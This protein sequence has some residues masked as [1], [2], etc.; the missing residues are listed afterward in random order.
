MD[1]GCYSHAV[2][3]REYKHVIA[4]HDG[5]AKR[6]I[7]SS[8]LIFCTSAG[9]NRKKRFFLKI[10]AKTVFDIRRTDSISLIQV[11]SME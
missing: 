5:Q 10:C 4:S 2:G 1:L 7:A 6:V 8:E 3:W 9:P 11:E